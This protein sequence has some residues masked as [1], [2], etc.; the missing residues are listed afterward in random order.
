MLVK[1]KHVGK[2]VRKLKAKSLK[3]IKMKG[4]IYQENKIFM[5]SLAFLT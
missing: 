5:R 3:S 4:T 2:N 1:R